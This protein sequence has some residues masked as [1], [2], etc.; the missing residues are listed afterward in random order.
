MDLIRSLLGVLPEYP[1]WLRV[2]V[3]VWLVLSAVLIGAFLL[4]PRSSASFGRTRDSAPVAARSE[5]SHYEAAIAGLLELDCSRHLAPSQP[6]MYTPQRL[7]C[8]ALAEL[9]HNLFH[10][11]QARRVLLGQADTVA[12]GPLHYAAIT[13]FIRTSYKEEEYGPKKNKLLTLVRDLESKAPPTEGTREVL[14]KWN[15]TS[16]LAPISWTRGLSCRCFVIQQ[17]LEGT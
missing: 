6:N 5:R 17:S 7:V 10:L 4:V 3:V 1:L 8:E 14:A 15:V 16:G 11:A 13:L 2:A 12:V 9:R